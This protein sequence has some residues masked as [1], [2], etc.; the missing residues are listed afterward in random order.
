MTAKRINNS[1]SF[2]SIG[3][4]TNFIIHKLNAY[5][6]DNYFVILMI[7][8]AAGTLFR[9]KFFSMESIW[10][11]AAVH[12]WYSIQ[13]ATDPLSMIFNVDYYIGDYAIPQTITALYYLFIDD[14]FVAGKL[15]AL[16][17]AILGMFFI[18]LLGTELKDKTTG[19][20]A[21]SLLAFNHIFVFY[22]V[23]PLGDA[24]LTVSFIIFLYCLVKFENV[25]DNYFKASK[26]P[27]DS[28]NRYTFLGNNQKINSIEISKTIHIDDV[29]F[30]NEDFNHKTDFNHKANF[31]LLSIINYASNNQKFVWAILTVITLMA[32]MLHKVQAVLFVIG[33]LLYLII[34]YRKTMFTN[35]NILFSWAVP[36]GI[37]LAAHFIA[38]TF[39]NSNL[40]G[41][42]FG[43]MTQL[44]GMPFGFEALEQLKWI[45]GFALI[46]LF[47]IAVILMIIFKEKKFRS[48][49]VIGIF[50]WMYFETS[51]DHTQDRYMLVLLP[52]G[53]LL[54]AYAITKISSIISSFSFKRLKPILILIVTIYLCFSSFTIADAL[55]E[56]KANS[57]MGM[58][59]AGE[60][61]KENVEENDLVFASSPRVIHAFADLDYYSEGALDSPLLGGNLYWLRGERYHENF[62]DYDHCDVVLNPNAQANFL[63][64]MANLSID[65]NIWLEIDIWEYT[66]PRWY[67]DFCGGSRLTM[68][69][70]NYFTT[71][72]FEVIHVVSRDFDPGEAVQESA[73]VFILKLNKGKFIAN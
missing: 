8:I 70:I 53:I 52:I 7:I 38:K 57:Y 67:Y 19:L 58:Q 11:D 28:T 23:R 44:R 45:H 27:V 72:G 12:L 36:T 56:S 73:V 48:L 60:F 17:Y 43:L 25:N 21:A 14:I 50:Y 32:T 9:L 40:L 46:I 3:D 4:F 64:D 13:M 15:M 71:L 31:Q 51:V 16:T 29:S 69:S 59:E 37:I 34:F 63:E 6:K 26:R 22:S 68:E 2:S 5:T 39:F 41:R 42:L 33:Y 18:Y 65:H 30:N 54:S 35:K 49:L 24:P 1:N 66:Q 10:N 20:V 47:V 55:V 61:I 62:R